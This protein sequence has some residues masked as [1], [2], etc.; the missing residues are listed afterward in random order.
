MKLYV[1]DDVVYIGFV[2]FDMCSLFINM[3]LMIWIEDVVFVGFVCNYVDG[4]VV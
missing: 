3:E 4:E 1:I 2:N